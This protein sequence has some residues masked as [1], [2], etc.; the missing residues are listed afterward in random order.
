[1]PHTTIYRDRDGLHHID[2]HLVPKEQLLF[3][4]ACG[5]FVDTER[6]VEVMIGD[7]PQAQADPP[8][9]ALCP[10]CFAA[11]HARRRQLRAKLAFDAFI[12][13]PIGFH[14]GPC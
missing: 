14:G 1:M 12:E 7:H 3:E 5:R 9:S 11:A 2:P 13:R 8:L 10:V 4:Y 6:D